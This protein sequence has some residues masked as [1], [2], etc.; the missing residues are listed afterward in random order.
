MIYLIE[1]EGRNIEIVQF[2]KHEKVLSCFSF[3][4]YPKN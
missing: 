4:I 2:K 1:D 3:Y